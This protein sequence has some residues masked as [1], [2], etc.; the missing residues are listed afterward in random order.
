MTHEQANALPAGPE[1]DEAACR[2]LGIEPKRRGCLCDG[3]WCSTPDYCGAV[4]YP[5][6]ST[7]GNAALEAMG[8]VPFMKLLCVFGREQNTWSASYA[9]CQGY[10]ETAPLA[11]A[12]AAAQIRKA[13]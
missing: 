5:P 4:V 1:L 2:G 9:D 11:I 6:I 7:N 12:R 8:R 13:E 3:Q 10:G